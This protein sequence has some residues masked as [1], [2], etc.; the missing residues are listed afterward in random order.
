ML[1]RRPFLFTLILCGLAVVG[2]TALSYLSYTLVGHRDPSLLYHV[3]SAI[4][5]AGILSPLFLSPLLHAAHQLAQAKQRLHR[6]AMTDALTGLPNARALYRLLEDATAPS[7]E[8]GFV[9]VF[10]DLDHFKNVN[11]TLGH[12]IGDKLLIAVSSRLQG[13]LDP[14][15]HLARFG[16]DEFVVIGCCGSAEPDVSA[17]ANKILEALTNPFVIEDHRLHIDATLGVACF[18]DHGSD[19]TTLLRAADLALYAAKSAKKGSWHV[20]DN[21]L[22]REAQKRRYLGSALRMAVDND[23]L[24]LHFQPLVSASDGRIRHCE[25]L[26]RWAI[27]GK[28]FVEP[29]EFIPIAEAEGLVP[30]IDDWALRR[31]CQA[32]IR[33]PDDISVAVNVSPQSFGYDDFLDKVREALDA[34]GLDP[35][36][37]TIEITETAL[38]RPADRTQKTIT[39]LRD[40]GIRI[41]LD[42]FGTGFSGLNHLAAFTLDQIKI[43]RTYLA[44]ALNGGRDRWLLEGV[45]ELTAG[46]GIDVVVEGVETPDM[47]DMVKNLPVDKMQGYLFCRP[48][49]ESEI[50]ALLDASAAIRPAEWTGR[51][52]A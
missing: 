6:D 35:A 7:R 38:L 42:D 33:W 45:A 52:T 41:S 27:G 31:A 20:F 28:E 3:I 36:R 10:V 8:E 43:D 21:D 13:I 34:S 12:P 49:P 17:I 46:L 44:R 4:V 2:A 5:I 40:L 1:A 50:S 9:L 16:G 51:K 37:L 11:D 19:P 47:L 18:P 24:D 39:Q 30:A 48:L 22:E 26:I 14:R 32:A 23:E 29:S 15:D 25:A